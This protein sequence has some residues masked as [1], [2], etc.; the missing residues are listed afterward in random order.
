MRPDV[1][2]ERVAQNRDYG[3]KD[4]SDP[5]FPRRAHYRLKPEILATSTRKSTK[6]NRPGRLKLTRTV[7]R[8]VPCRN[9]LSIHSLFVALAL[10]GVATAQTWQSEQPAMLL[11]GASPATGPDGRVYVVGGRDYYRAGRVKSLRS[12]P[13]FLGLCRQPEVWAGLSRNSN[14]LRRKD[15]RHRWRALQRGGLRSKN[16]SVDF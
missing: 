8:A 13:E 3:P 5:V 7:A 2:Q 14:R 16:E 10:C 6:M 1:V 9:R 12:P 4:F 15:L 11:T